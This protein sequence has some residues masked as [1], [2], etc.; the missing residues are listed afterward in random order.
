METSAEPRWLSDDE[1]QAW[2]ALVGVM[3]RLPSALDAQLQRDAGLSHFEYMVLAGLSEAPGRTR[4]M[5][6]LAGF[7]ESGLPR[8]SQVVGRLEKRGWVRRSP[9]PSDGRITLATLTDDGWAKVVQTAP[10]HI[11]AVRNLVFD[12]LTKAQSRQLGDI[13]DRIMHAI[14]TTCRPRGAGGGST[15]I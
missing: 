9:D 5:S 11:E 7:T 15:A 13:G 4:R 3:M 2:L 12:P 14:D 8:L 6:E 1:R 10:G